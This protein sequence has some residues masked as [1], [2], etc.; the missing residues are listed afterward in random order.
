MPIQLGTVAP[1]GFDDFPRGAWLARLRRLGCTVVQ[2]YRRQDAGL[3]AAEMRDYLDAG[4]LPC[5]SLHGLFGASLDPSS[6]HEGLRRS[7]VETYRSEG[8]LALELGGSLVVVH[9]SPKASSPI[10][11]DE[12]RRRLDALRSSA[13]ELGRYGE[14]IGVTYAFENLPADHGVGRDPAELAQLLEGLAA[15][16]TA[17]CFDTGHALITGDPAAA[18]AACGRQIAYVHFSDNAGQADDHEMPTRGSMDTGAVADALAAAGFSGTLMLEVF[19]RIEAL[20]E[21]I[22]SGL[23]ERLAEILVRASAPP[24]AG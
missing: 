8:R 10:A 11:P 23:A 3:T 24:A 18:I 9:C 2:A 15:P 21:M 16:N 5:D 20:D 12:Y 6:P 1:I 14:R 22:A 7:T 19:Q 13:A 17:M 4:E